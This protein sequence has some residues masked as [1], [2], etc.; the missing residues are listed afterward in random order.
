M[1]C[2]LLFDIL[3]F[4]GSLAVLPVPTK[5]TKNRL[6]ETFSIAVNKILAYI[7]YLIMY[8]LDIYE[9]PLPVTELRYHWQHC[10]DKNQR[11]NDFL[12]KTQV[13]L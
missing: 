5:L 1:L 11:G 10:I 7:T 3:R 9:N 8:Y 13:A 4:V 12:H 2:G 6:F